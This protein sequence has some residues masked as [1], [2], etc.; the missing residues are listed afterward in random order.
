MIEWQPIETVPKDGSVVRLKRLFVHNGRTYNLWECDGQWCPDRGGF[1]RDG[2]S[3]LEDLIDPSHWR[4]LKDTTMTF[5]INQE[6]DFPFIDDYADLFVVLRDAY[7]QSACGKGRERHANDAPFACQP[8][9]T[10]TDLIGGDVAGMAFQAIKKTSEATG[11]IRRNCTD[12]AIRELLGA[13]VYN[14]GIIVYLRNNA[15]DAQ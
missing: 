5:Q 11:M 12:A 7:Q 9:Q 13:I 10:I 1:I 2:S 8:M 4:R 3:D 15:K 14:A 6:T